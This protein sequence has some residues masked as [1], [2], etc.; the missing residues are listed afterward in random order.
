[1]SKSISIPGSNGKT[2][3]LSIVSETPNG[4]IYG[5]T[6]GGLRLL[7]IFLHFFCKYNFEGTKLMYKRDQMLQLR[8]SPYAQTPPKL[9]NIPGV[10]TGASSVAH[11]ETNKLEQKENEEPKTHHDAHPDDDMDDQFEMDA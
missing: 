6:P 7:F 8:G 10:T 3:N 2:V 5:V 11:S 4:T 9:P 1:M